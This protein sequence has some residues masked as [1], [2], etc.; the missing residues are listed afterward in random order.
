MFRFYQV[1]VKAS[2][3]FLAGANLV[4]AQGK[5]QKAHVHGKAAVNVAFDGLKGELEF[6]SPADGILGFEHE[7]RTAAEK[8]AQQ[9]ALNTLKNKAAEIFLLPSGAGC[10]LKPK[11]VEVHRE[12]ANHAEVHAEYT[13]TCAKAPKGEFRIAITK[14]FPKTQEVNVQL[15]AGETQKSATIKGDRGALTF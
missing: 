9:Q 8:Q 3:V 14:F 5:S 13:I 10:Q 11:E 12:G 6:E 7:A 1:I 15:V 2:L 4:V